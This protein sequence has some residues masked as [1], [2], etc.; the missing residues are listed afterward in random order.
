MTEAQALVTDW[1][2]KKKAAD[3]AVLEERS[4]RSAMINAIFPNVEEGAGNEFVIGY[5]FMLKV[6]GV[7]TR[8]LDV[9]ALDAIKTTIPTDVYDAVIRTKPELSVTGW[10]ALPASAKNLFATCVTEEPGTSSAKIIPM[11]KPAV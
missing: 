2:A 5:G 9:G 11:K 10:K 7:I 8:K 3:K 1:D 6:T 4:A